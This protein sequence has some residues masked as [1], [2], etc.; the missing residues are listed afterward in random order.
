M[1]D[2]LTADALGK[3]FRFT[4]AVRDCSLSLPAGR[5]IA[6]VGPNGAG[7]STFLRMAA[8]LVRPTTG[9]IDVLGHNPFNQSGAEAARVGY[10]DQERPLLRNFTA[11]A[12]VTLAAQMNPRFD[13]GASLRYLCDVRIPLANSIGKLSVGQRAQV[14]LAL[15]VGKRPEL[16]I[17]DEPLDG[18]DPLARHDLMTHLMGHVAG[19]SATVLFSS[20]LVS[21]LEPVCDYLVVLSASR[22]Q[23]VGDIDVLAATHRNLIGPRWSGEPL[24][25]VAAVIHE[26]TTE[27]QSTL[28]VRTDGELDTRG[29]Q[30]VEPTLEDIVLAYLREQR[31]AASA[32][33]R[34]SR[35]DAI[36]NPPSRSAHV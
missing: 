29:W 8:G 26:D 30:V 18:L 20:H 35:H 34:R 5:V 14:A 25:G 22:V 1:T 21:E 2:V 3:R 15:V 31:P 23:L 32:P 36:D 33:R 9:T 11:E 16:L 13:M 27:R 17:L 19:S 12:M 4:W 24:A 10:L 7:K 6:L 28:V